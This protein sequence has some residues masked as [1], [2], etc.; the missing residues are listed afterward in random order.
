MK[1]LV[2]QLEALTCPTC[3]KKIETA[4]SNLKGV[5][6][7]KVLFNSSK[8]KIEYDESAITTDKIKNTIIKL[9]YEVLGARES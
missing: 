2:L 6:S 9:G 1:K 7:I 4:V 8:A 5:A 3:S